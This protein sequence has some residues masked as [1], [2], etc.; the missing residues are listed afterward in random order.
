MTTTRKPAG[1]SDIIRGS[2]DRRAASESRQALFD[3]LEAWFATASEYQREVVDF[4][5]NRLAKNSDT[6]REM[7]GCRN[8][9]DAMAIHARWVQETIRDYSAERTRMLAIYTKN[10]AD[11]VQ[12]K[13]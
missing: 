5:S 12:T 9:A 10:A 7:L 13:R 8:P 11:A 2:F 4:V 1:L 6:M 3:G